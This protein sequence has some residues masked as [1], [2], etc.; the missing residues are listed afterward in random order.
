MYILLCYLGNSDE[1]SDRRLKQALEEGGIVKCKSIVAIFTGSAGVGKTSTVDLLLHPEASYQGQNKRT[2]TELLRPIKTRL[3][4]LGE[5]CEW[6][7]VVSARSEIARLANI[8]SLPIAE[9]K[10]VDNSSDDS[11]AGQKR[12]EVQQ[13]ANAQPA[14]DAGQSQLNS[15]TGQEQEDSTAKS[16]TKKEM[17]ELE[18]LLNEV[19]KKMIELGS[20]RM[21]HTVT[22][23]YLLDSGGQ[24]HF[25]ELLES[26]LP[27][28]SVIV[29]VVNLNER[30]DD[31][32]LV[33][34]VKKDKEFCTYYQSPS[35]HEHL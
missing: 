1:E 3:G 22:Y 26:F 9:D 35:S 4:T 6:T 13:N 27:E 25:H 12:E 32:P 28:V 2:S 21:E 33:Q 5:D 24:P 7:E 30:L 17:E 31:F 16:K 11:A 29:F 14:Y 8:A 10:G 34:C 20:E 23:M 19:A 15:T 18:Q